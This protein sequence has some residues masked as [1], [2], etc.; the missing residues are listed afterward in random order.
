MLDPDAPPEQRQSPVHPPLVIPNRQRRR[1]GDPLGITG[2]LLSTMY[3]PL[4]LPPQLRYREG[5]G[6][7]PFKTPHPGSC[8]FSEGRPGR[9]RS[10]KVRRPEDYSTVPQCRAEHRISRRENPRSS[11]TPGC[12]LFRDHIT[13]PYRDKRWR[14]VTRR[15]YLH[16]T[17]AKGQDPLIPPF[18]IRGGGPDP[19]GMDVTG[20]LIFHS[21]NERRVKYSRLTF[22]PQRE[23]TTG[24]GR[25]K[26]YLPP[27][28]ALLRLAPLKETNKGVVLIG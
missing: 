15:Y 7:S 18:L 2:P 28:L 25:H 19:V 12:E 21:C 27:F 13:P 20:C 23:D 14:I 17:E 3:S 9:C 22:R 16:C 11:F 8:G 4:S 1:K 5:R 26:C 10:L 6:E 24:N